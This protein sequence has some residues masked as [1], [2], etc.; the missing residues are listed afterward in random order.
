M[1]HEIFS[2]EQ[3]ELLPL[4]KCFRR[5]FYL[6]GGTAIALH[7][8]HRKSIDFDLFKP[9]PFSSKKILNKIDETH[10]HYNITR[11]VSEQLNLTILNVKFTFFEYPYPV[12]ASIDFNKILRMPDLLTLAAMKAF[13]L[14]R[15]SKWKDYVDLYFLIKEYF[16]VNDI[17]QKATI[18]FG[19]E[20]SGKLFRSQLAYHKDIDYSESVEFMNGYEEKEE[21]IKAFLIEKALEW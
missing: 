5:E 7:I 4:L 15:R 8:G 1:H 10:Y 19:Q 14:G 9:K 17:I 20:F 21:V 3:N 2:L 6:V 11:R 18:I 12:E 13:A 16:S